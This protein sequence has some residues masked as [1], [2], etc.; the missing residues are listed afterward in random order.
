VEMFAVLKTDCW[1]IIE[2]P[3]WLFSANET[4]SLDDLLLAPHVAVSYAFE[5][6]LMMM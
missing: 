1:L 6:Y 4:F 2:C 3:W 5:R